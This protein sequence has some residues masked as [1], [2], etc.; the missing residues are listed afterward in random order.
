M[1]RINRF[2]QEMSDLDD[3]DNNGSSD[4]KDKS[5]ETSDSAVALNDSFSCNYKS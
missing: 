5:S 3:D 4:D 1:D 2:A